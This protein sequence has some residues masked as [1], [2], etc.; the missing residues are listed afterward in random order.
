MRKNRSP[1][2]GQEAMIDV[3]GAIVAS[4][5]PPLSIAFPRGAAYARK[6]AIE[7]CFSDIT[8]ANRSI[9]LFAMSSAHPK[10]DSIDRRYGIPGAMKRSAEHDN[11]ARKKLLD[12]CANCA[13]L[14]CGLRGNYSAFEEKYHKA[15]TRDKFKKS[16]AKNPTV[17]C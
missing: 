2:E 17:P 7:A 13:I 14:N 12:A 16:L 15:P 1:G 11:A 10:Y 5:L 9:G 6:A 3:S 8:R 4:A